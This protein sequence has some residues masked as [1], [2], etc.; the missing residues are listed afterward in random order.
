MNAR[1][2]AGCALLVAL[3]S[4]SIA[5][6]WPSSD[7][8]ASEVLSV[9]PPRVKTTFTITE[10][11][12]TDPGSCGWAAFSVQ[13]AE[14][15]APGAPHFFSCVGSSPWQCALA[16]EVGVPT[17]YFYPDGG[18][19]DPRQDNSFSITTDRPEPC[20]RVEYLCIVLM[21]SPS[22]P[23]EA[24]LSVMPSCASRPRSKAPRRPPTARG[25]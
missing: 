22:A 4:P 21:G 24:C 11:G 10:T 8:T 18:G 2:A 16:D 9:D 3:A 6:A 5:L 25:R 7:V 17:L 1:V 15:T 12:P 23:F 20:V 19:G 14:P 13:A